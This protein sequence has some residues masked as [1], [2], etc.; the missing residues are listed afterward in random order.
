MAFSVRGNAC[1]YFSGVRTFSSAPLIPKNQEA[2][3]AACSGCLM[4]T[5]NRLLPR[6]GK[7]SRNSQYTRLNTVLPQ[8]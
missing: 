4:R 6:L 8:G 5:D 7:F 2:Q 1:E 3:M